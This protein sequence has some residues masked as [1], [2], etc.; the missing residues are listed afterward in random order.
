MHRTVA[1]NLRCWVLLYLALR[2]LNST[3]CDIFV[4]T[5]YNVRNN[6]AML[7]SWTNSLL[8]ISVDLCHVL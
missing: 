4:L 6:L 5:L 2:V 8:T 1:E 7:A 3:T